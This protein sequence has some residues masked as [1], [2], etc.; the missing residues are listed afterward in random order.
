MNCGIHAE[1]EAVGMCVDCG[2]YICQICLNK[3]AGK[4]YCDTCAQ[5]RARSR[6]VAS[7]QP[8]QTYTPPQQAV[9]VLADK[10]KI[11]AGVL[12]L[13]FGGFGVHK[14]YLGEIGWGVMYALFF[15][16]GIPAFAGFIEGIVY[17]SMRE[18]KFAQKYGSVMRR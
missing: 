13:V 10:N 2:T 15:W 8:V 1:R 14:F 3:E 11:A 5:M 6:T 4:M 18:E 9:T 7:H 12:A 17:L 16:T